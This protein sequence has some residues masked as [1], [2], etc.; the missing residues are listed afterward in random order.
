MFKF[1]N[2]ISLYHY[3]IIS[4]YNYY[5]I[6]NYNYEKVKEIILKICMNMMFT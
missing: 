5:I 2:I 1:Y 3:Y 4:L 6:F